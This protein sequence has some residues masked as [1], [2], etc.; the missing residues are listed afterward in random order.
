[1]IAAAEPWPNR[2]RTNTPIDGAN[3]QPIDANT[4][5]ASPKPNA[6][7]APTRS[8][9]APDVNSSPANINVYPSTTHCRPL[10]P[11]PR[12]SRIDGNATFTTT[13]SNVT[14]KNP[15]SAAANVPAER[16]SPDGS[17]TVDRCSVASSTTPILRAA[18]TINQGR[19]IEVLP[20]PP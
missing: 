5:S 13:A 18:T 3:P 17:V 11:P 1:M 7:R 4:K 6:R 9:T 8:A 2:A 15:S 19:L 20:A 14:T 16:A 12:S 10:I